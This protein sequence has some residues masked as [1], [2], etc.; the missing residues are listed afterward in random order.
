VQAPTRWR[1]KKGHTVAPDA[2]WLADWDLIALVSGGKE[3]H[4]NGITDCYTVQ[5][6]IKRDSKSIMWNQSLA[7]ASIDMLALMSYGIPPLDLADRASIVFTMLLTVMAFKFVLAET[8]PSVPYLTLFDKFMVSRYLV[9]AVQGML[10]W[11][12]AELDMHLCNWDGM[13]FLLKT[14]DSGHPN[15]TSLP[16][17]SDPA[18]TGGHTHGIWKGREYPYNPTPDAC[19]PIHLFDRLQM[20]VHIVFVLCKYILFV[21]YYL[22]SHVKENYDGKL[23]S[24]QDLEE[25]HSSNIMQPFKKS[26][27]ELSGSGGEGSSEGIELVV[28][29]RR[30]N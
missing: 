24:T 8:L 6:I 30:R 19:L 1:Y 21:Y 10:H 14:V 3:I 29:K 18:Y 2:D 23:L 4:N 15:M 5:L 11:L 27:V 25:F 16:D 17:N 26:V 9:F 28:S 20:L 22:K 7:L 12:V 13:D